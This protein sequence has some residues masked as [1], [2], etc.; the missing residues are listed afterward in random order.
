VSKNATAVAELGVEL[1]KAQHPEP[2]AKKG[3]TEEAKIL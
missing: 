2:F 3:F 1:M